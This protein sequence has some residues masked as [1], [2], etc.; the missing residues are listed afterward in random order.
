MG[1]DYFYGQEA[2]QFT[3]YRIPKVLFTDERF[4][5]LSAEAKLLYGLLLDRM[6]LS[7]RN[8]WFDDQ[9]RVY[10][11]FTMFTKEFAFTGA[12]GERF[13]GIIWYPACS[14]S[15]VVQ[16]THGMTEHI[17]RYEKLA[18]FLTDYGIAV[19]GFD[20]RGH[21]RNPGDSQCASFGE[22]G[23]K[24]SLHDMHL[25][26][27]ELE[28]RFPGIPHFMLGFSLGSFPLRDYLGIY[29]DKVDGAIIMGTG[30]QPGMV[31]NTLM[32]VVK[33][34]IKAHGFDNSTQRI[35]KLSFETYNQKHLRLLPLTGCAATDSSF[36][37][38]VPTRC[39]GRKSPQACSGSCWIP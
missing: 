37:N 36:C 30:H 38:T 34:E 26:Y 18:E 3:F 20:L 39:A 17:G 13:P 15:M 31:L 1:L 6:A 14:P 33:H 21:G 9:N 23:W 25:F 2:D 19:A 10:I 7:Q 22:N 24:L 27:L 5:P 12:N 35:R 11:I 8:G 16:I 29:S 4:R 28:S 32:P